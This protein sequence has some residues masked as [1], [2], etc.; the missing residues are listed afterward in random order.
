M[1]KKS[2]K[3]RLSPLKVKQFIQ[4]KLGLLGDQCSNFQGFFPFFFICFPLPSSEIL[5]QKNFIYFSNSTVGVSG[6]NVV[7]L[8]WHQYDVWLRHSLPHVGSEHWSIC[9]LLLLLKPV[10]RSLILA[11]AMHGD[12]SQE[13][14]PLPSAKQAVYTDFR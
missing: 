3:L 4:D 12:C 2:E 14:Q 13:A 1:E 5:S 8:S 11:Q 7:H 6:L 9:L 10:S